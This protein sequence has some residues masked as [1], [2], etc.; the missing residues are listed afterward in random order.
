MV[1]AHDRENLR[2]VVG[3]DKQLWI[4]RTDEVVP[5]SD[6][7]LLEFWND[8]SILETTI[9]DGNHHTLSQESSLVEL[10]ALQT[11]YLLGSGAV[12]F[13]G[14]AVVGFETLVIVDARVR[15]DGV[16][17]E[18]YQ[19]AGFYAGQLAD[20]VDEC[21]VLCAHQDGVLPT[22]LAYN[23]DTLTAYHADIMRRYG[24]VG[25]V[26][27]KALAPTSLDGAS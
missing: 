14:T 6:V 7:N 8:V 15:D 3:I 17:R 12:Y 25:R 9:E 24:Q 21:R 4:V 20:A 16:G 5:A 19:P 2:A 1:G 18:P 10:V 13:C 23:A 11:V 22:A 27:G 26:E